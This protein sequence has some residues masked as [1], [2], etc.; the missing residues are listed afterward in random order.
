ME[1]RIILCDNIPCIQVDEGIQAVYQQVMHPNPELLDDW[2][3][4]HVSNIAELAHAIQYHFGPTNNWSEATRTRIANLVQNF[5]QET[6]CAQVTRGDVK[7]MIQRT[8]D[9]ILTTHYSNPVAHPDMD[10]ALSKI[11]KLVNQLTN[12]R[13]SWSVLDQKLTSIPME[14]DNVEHLIQT[15]DFDYRP[16]LII[17][18]L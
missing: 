4:E 6:G 13:Y 1:I 9:C 10:L 14:E 11:P 3:C 17:G 15:L 2:R 8:I 5:N 18:E 16:L 12:W 7:E